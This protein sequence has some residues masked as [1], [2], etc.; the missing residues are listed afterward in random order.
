MMESWIDEHVIPVCETL[1][2][3][4]GDMPPSGRQHHIL[5]TICELSRRAQGWPKLTDREGRQP[6]FCHCRS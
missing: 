1:R 5:C 2:E 6:H 3:A 4:E